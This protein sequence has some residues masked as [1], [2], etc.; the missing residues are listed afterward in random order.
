M[1]ILGLDPGLSATGWA[2]LLRSGELR[3]YGVIRPKGR[4]L[5]EKLVCLHE[6]VQ[7]VLHE[8]PPTLAVMET[9]IYHKNPRTALSL[10]A[11]RGVILLALAQREIPV[12]E[13]SPTD[14]K[15]SITG[16]GAAP[17]EQVAFMVRYLLKLP[18][19]LPHHA[20]DAMACALS[21]IRREIF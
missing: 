20:T 3:A 5:G 21:A 12:V 15:L 8:Y 2:V 6:E 10:G 18:Q 19:P 9:V 4:T 13:L 11:A 7:R 16:S 14:I 1:R 17:K